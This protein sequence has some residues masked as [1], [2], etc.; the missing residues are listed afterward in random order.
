MGGSLEAQQKTQADKVK[1]K[2]TKKQTTIWTGYSDDWVLE[3]KEHS[4]H[5]NE[6]LLFCNDST[7]LT[8]RG[9]VCVLGGRGA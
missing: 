7:E 6:V 1:S 9:W 8:P 2:R 4:K 3:I 5:R